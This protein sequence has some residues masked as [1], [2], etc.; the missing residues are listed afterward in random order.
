M[1]TSVATSRRRL[2]AVGLGEEERAL[3]VDKA[4]AD[5][6]VLFADN[7]DARR[8]TSEHADEPVLVVARFSES[9]SWGLTALLTA[10][11][12]VGQQPTVILLADVPRPALPVLITD[13]PGLITIDPQ[14]RRAL[15][16]ALSAVL[17]GDDAGSAPKPAA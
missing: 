4:G 6:T 8:W 16:S 10:L 9:D 15:E 1:S 3:V 2:L 17:R 12:Q 5:G 14:D 11:Q 7:V 13:H